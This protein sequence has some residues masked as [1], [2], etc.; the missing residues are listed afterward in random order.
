MSKRF[1]E[2]CEINFLNTRDMNNHMKTKKHIKNTFIKEEIKRNEKKELTI[3]DT[4]MTQHCCS[5]CDYT[6]DDNSNLNRHIN[7]IHK[8]DMDEI[9]DKLTKISTEYPFYV[10][11]NYLVLI[12]S[13]ENTR[14]RVSGLK[15]RINRLI[16]RHYDDDE[17]LMIETKLDH[18]NA[19][20][21]LDHL[22]ARIKDLVSK[23]PTVDEELKKALSNARKEE[24]KK[25]NEEILKELEELE[26]D[27]KNK[28]LIIAQKMEEIE[29][30]KKI[31]QEYKINHSLN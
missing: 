16:N 18:K 3:D 6:S 8:E 2:I 10:L 26:E 29:E 21:R 27:K 1:C 28:E 19:S 25:E 17:P 4:V 15:C 9:N 13:L 14:L 30:V 11:K 20:E 7:S 24:L 12:S 23:Y 5:F 31:I 22:K